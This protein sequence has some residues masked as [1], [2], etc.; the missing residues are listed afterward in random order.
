V[1]AIAGAFAAAL[2]TGAPC[3]QPSSKIRVYL[4]R[5]QTSAADKAMRA[6]LCL[7]VPTRTTVASLSGRIVVDR[8]M[9]RVSNV[10]TPRNAQLV[11]RTDSANR[12]LIAGASPRGLRVGTLL[13]LRLELARPGVLPHVELRIA[14]L[15]APNGGSLMTQATIDGLATRCIGSAPGIERI[16][17]TEATAD[18]GAVLEITVT[19]CAFHVAKNVIRVGDVTLRNI[20]SSASG[21]RI[22]VVVPKEVRG[23]SGAP[24]MQM[25]AG[26]Y[27]V[28]VN[29]GRGTSN[30][31]QITLR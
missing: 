6:R 13:S 1:I 24:P 22:H 8:N 4:E 30:V 18:P 29:N 14:E 9:A 19:G 31:V 17:P 16:E 20:A 28:T 12:V 27:A 15:S 3:T 5:E 10:V 7:A 26:T 21:T 2:V 23:A 11:V 25:A